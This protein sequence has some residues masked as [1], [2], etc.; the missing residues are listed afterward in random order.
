MSCG[1]RNLE[2]YYYNENQAKN[3][4]EYLLTPTGPV[5]RDRPTP[6]PSV[7]EN[8]QTD[9]QPYSYGYAYATYK[10]NDLYAYYPKETLSGVI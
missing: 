7:V 5:V 2:T 9:R 6:T 3:A 1:Y 10:A 8:Y 4:Y